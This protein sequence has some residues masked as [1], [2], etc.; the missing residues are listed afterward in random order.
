[1]AEDTRKQ[2]RIDDEV[3][4]PWRAIAERERRSLTKQTEAVLDWALP[5]WQEEHD[6]E[7]VTA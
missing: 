7:A 2:I 5:R 3:L 4:E 6:R 1:M